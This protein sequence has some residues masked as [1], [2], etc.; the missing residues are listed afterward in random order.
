MYA[1]S[2]NTCFSI[3]SML[4]YTVFQMTRGAAWFILLITFPNITISAII[5]EECRS[6][7]K[8]YANHTQKTSLFEQ[9]CLH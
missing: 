9:I 6:V 1:I 3:T 8:I 4:S 7:S 5:I 2:L